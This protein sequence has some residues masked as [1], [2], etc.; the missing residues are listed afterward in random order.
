MP[1]STLCFHNRNIMA[2]LKVSCNLLNRLINFQ[3]SII[4]ILWLY[5]R[6]INPI[7]WLNSPI[8]SIIEILWLYWRMSIDSLIFNTTARF[9]NRNIMALLKDLIF[10][11]YGHRQ[12]SFHNRNIMALLKELKPDI[13]N[14]IYPCFHNRNIMALLK[15]QCPIWICCP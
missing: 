15:D 1:V 2:L 9:H 11:F 5:W 8:V 3:V 14:G 4:E 10:W 7:A 12:P 6:W 13:T